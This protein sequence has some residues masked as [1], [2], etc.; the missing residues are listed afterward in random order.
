VHGEGW[1][2]SGFGQAFVVCAVIAAVAAVIAFLAV[3]PGRVEMGHDAL[4]MH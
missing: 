1:P 4:P 2:V 3:R